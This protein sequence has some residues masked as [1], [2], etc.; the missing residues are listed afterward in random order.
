MATTSDKLRL[1]DPHKHYLSFSKTPRLRVTEIKLESRK[2]LINT[3]GQVQ[4]KLAPLFEG[5]KLDIENVILEFEYF[6]IRGQLDPA[7]FSAEPFG[8]PFKPDH[9]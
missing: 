8:K 3:K 7:K 4:F 2:Q 6:D 9:L 1:R 5:Q